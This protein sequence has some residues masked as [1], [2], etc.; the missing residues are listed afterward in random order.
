MRSGIS[1]VDRLLDAALAMTFPASDPVAVWMPED[2]ISRKARAPKP[3]HAD[4]RARRAA[5][6]AKRRSGR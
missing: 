1:H 3:V 6:L 2:P 4:P 5:G